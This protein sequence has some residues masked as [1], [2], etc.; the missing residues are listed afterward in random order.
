MG[1]MKQMFEKEDL[2]NEM[3]EMAFDLTMQILDQ[4]KRDVLTQVEILKS[5]ADIYAEMVLVNASFRTDLERHIAKDCA[6]E[7]FKLAMDAFK[8]VCE[9]VLRPDYTG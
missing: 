2:I 4:G 9:E 5:H 8:T 1:V 7:S 3:N 6:K